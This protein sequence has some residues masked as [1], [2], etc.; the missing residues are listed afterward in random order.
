MGEEPRAG[1]TQVTD[2][3]P[4]EPLE[5]RR[6]IEATRS[7]LG[8]TVEALA[9]KTDVKAQAQRKVADV[10]Q[11]LDRKRSELVGKAR[12]STPDSAGSTASTVTRKARDNPMALAVAGAFAAGVILGW[13]ANR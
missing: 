12:R 3:G 13:I 1:S 2:E 9:H 11:S 10:R 7:E 4:R 5:I 8:D 6:D